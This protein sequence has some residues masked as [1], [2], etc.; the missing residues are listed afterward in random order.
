[1]HPVRNGGEFTPRLAKYKINFAAIRFSPPKSSLLTSSEQAEQFVLGIRDE[2]PEAEADY[3][4]HGDIANPRLR[5]RR[6][7]LLIK[8]WMADFMP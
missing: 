6:Y 4:L 2:R 1:M 8:D 5:R 3:G 7:R